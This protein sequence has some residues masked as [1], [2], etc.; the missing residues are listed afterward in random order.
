VSDN[1]L[2]DDLRAVFVF[3]AATMGC[4]RGVEEL[5][6]DAPIVEITQPDGQLRQCPADGV[7]LFYPQGP[8][9][10]DGQAPAHVALRAQ[11]LAGTCEQI[12]ERVTQQIR[13]MFEVYRSWHREHLLATDA[14]Y[15]A[16][17]ADQAI[18]LPRVPRP[19]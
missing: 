13:D 9:R 19:E 5:P 7:I 2:P 4:A 10:K 18:A 17:T 11:A 16:R 12:I 1:E 8:T 3:A 15:R 6:A 14:I